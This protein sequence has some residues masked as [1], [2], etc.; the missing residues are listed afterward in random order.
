MPGM[1]DTHI[2]DVINTG[3]FESHRLC[4]V[5]GDDP[6]GTTYSIQYVCPDHETLQSYIRN[7]APALQQDHKS[8]FEGHFVAFRTLLKWIN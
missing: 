2:P 3:K 8:K 1:I 5:L 4:K 6:E 7:D